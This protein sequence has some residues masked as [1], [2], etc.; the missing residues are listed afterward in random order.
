MNSMS[1]FFE[2]FDVF[3]GE[4]AH[5]VKV[6]FLKGLFMTWIILEIYVTEKM[7]EFSQ[8][9]PVY[10]AWFYFRMG[11]YDSGQGITSELAHRS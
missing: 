6:K 5:S 4:L 2:E 1:E 10:A 9:D 3:F 8:L 11:E 7:D